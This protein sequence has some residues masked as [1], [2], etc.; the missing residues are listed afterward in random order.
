MRAAS[1]GMIVSRLDPDV[2]LESLA[3]SG[4]SQNEFSTSS[5]KVKTRD[6]IQKN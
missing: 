4:G 1:F 3:G 5:K 2:G 6:K